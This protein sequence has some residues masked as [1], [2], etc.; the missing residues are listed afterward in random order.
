M[1][2][3]RLMKEEE[4]TEQL[5]KSKQIR[6]Q[7]PQKLNFFVSRSQ[8]LFGIRENELWSSWKIKMDL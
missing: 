2:T 4:R 1:Q 8:R 5:I 6:I 3:M 7:F